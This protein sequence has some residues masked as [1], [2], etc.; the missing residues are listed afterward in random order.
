[1]LNDKQKRFCEEYIVDLNATQAAIRAGYSKKTAGSQAHDLLKKPE[2]QTL[3]QQLND[4]RS[5]R[6]GITADIVLKE[7]AKLATS[8]IRKIMSNPDGGMVRIEDLDDATA[9]AIAGVEVVKRQTGEHDEDGNPIY[10][11]VVKYKFWDKNKSLEMLGRH[12]KMFTDK[13]EFEN[14]PKVIIRSYTTKGE[15]DAAGV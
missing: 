14:M 13:L 1:M 15:D 12:F 7:L 6:T 5:E 4:E 10:E 8:D 2:I 11:D 3:I 9:A